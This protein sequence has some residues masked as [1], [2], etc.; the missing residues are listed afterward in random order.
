LLLNESSGYRQQRIIGSE[1]VEHF[2]RQGHEVF[3]VDNN[4][5]ACFFCPTGD[6]AVEPGASEE[7]SETL[8]ARRD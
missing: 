2:D 7:Y 1:A 5:R 6:N 3:G 8:Y 4:M